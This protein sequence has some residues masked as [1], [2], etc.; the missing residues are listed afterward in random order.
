MSKIYKVTNNINNK[1]Y[2]GQ[3]NG[4]RKSYKGGGKILK[5]A[6]K[7]YG[8]ENF[9]M[10]TIVEGNFNNILLDEL[11]KHYIH[12]YNSTNTIK[13][14]NIESGGNF[15][16]T[17]K[18]S[19]ETKLKISKANKG[20]KKPPRTELHKKNMSLAK[21]GLKPNVSKE[22]KER[23]V[24]KFKEKMCGR[25]FSE[26]HKKQLYIAHI[27]REILCYK[28][29]VLYKKYNTSKECQKDLG[30]SINTIKKKIKENKEYKGYTFQFNNIK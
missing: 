17:F 21:K 27:V 5:I 28:S 1:I 19:E 14:Y 8:I 16:Y 7:K 10:E 12:L 25:K 11:E 20:R 22:T 24:Q 13:G 3:T 6:Y 18:M 15:N 26:E 2:I 23:A 30:I 9:T 29:G 4:K